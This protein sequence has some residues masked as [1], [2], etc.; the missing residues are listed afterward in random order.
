[1]Y[2]LVVY[3]FIYLNYS[4][5]QYIY[6]ILLLFFSYCISEHA[7]KPNTYGKKSWMCFNRWCDYTH[8]P[9]NGWFTSFKYIFTQ[10]H[11]CSSFCSKIRDML[12]WLDF[13]LSCESK[14]RTILIP[15]CLYIIYTFMYVSVKTSVSF[16]LYCETNHIMEK[17]SFSND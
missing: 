16:W 4:V 12:I 9:S 13:S 11:S 3:L 15:L 17:S 1:M 7:T 5:L 8:Y 2:G 14:A 6:I 10:N